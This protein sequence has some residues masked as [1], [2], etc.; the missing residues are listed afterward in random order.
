[1]R[2]KRQLAG[3]AFV[4]ALAASA[5][6]CGQDPDCTAAAEKLEACGL[7][8]FVEQYDLDT[9][10]CEDIAA[11]IAECVE[12]KSCEELEDSIAGGGWTSIL[13]AGEDCGQIGF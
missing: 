5:Q 2:W 9:C 4:V 7:G 11:C 13:C 6:G 3:M 8:R 10:A 1:M 12:V